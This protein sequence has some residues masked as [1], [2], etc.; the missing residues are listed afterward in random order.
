MKIHIEQL[1]FD[2]IIGL[3][4]HERLTPQ[5]VIVDLELTYDYTDHFIN[6]ADLTQ[7]IQ[8][9]LSDEKFELL[10]EALNELFNRISKS[11]PSTK[12]L[13]VKLSKPDI[14]PN[15]RVCVSNFKEF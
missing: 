15:C 5:R 4:D 11:Y 9:C 10:E 7:L 13:D 14:L 2:C 6:Y 1:T 12:T 8:T 3:L